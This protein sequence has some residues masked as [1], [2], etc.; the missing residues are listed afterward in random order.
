MS[1]QATKQQNIS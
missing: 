1:Q